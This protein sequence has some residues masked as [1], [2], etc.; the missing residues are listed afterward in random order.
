M[1]TL[2]YGYQLPETGDRGGT[3]FPALEDNIEQINDHDH[4]GSDSA[5]ILRKNIV[6]NFQTA[7]SA[8]AWSAQGNGLY[9]QL[10]TAPAG[11]FYTTMSLEFRTSATGDVFYPTVEYVSS[12]T[13]YIYVN[14][15][16]LAPVV[17]W[18]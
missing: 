5:L 9:R 2:S 16:S 11:Y 17:V 8:G 14:D 3:V 15:N 6:S 7:L 1:Q 13:F 4:D 10:V 12:T 18:G